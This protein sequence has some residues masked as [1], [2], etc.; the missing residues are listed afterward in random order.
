VD[1]KK[2]FSKTARKISSNNSN[3]V[4]GTVLHSTKPARMLEAELSG[5]DFLAGK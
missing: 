3:G 2:K 5:A 4:T 1:L